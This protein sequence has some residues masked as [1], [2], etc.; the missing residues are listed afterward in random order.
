MKVYELTQKVT[1]KQCI[2]LANLWSMWGQLVKRLLFFLILY[3]QILS[4]FASRNKKMVGSLIDLL[5]NDS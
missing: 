5:K 4:L 2:E 3:I 1:M